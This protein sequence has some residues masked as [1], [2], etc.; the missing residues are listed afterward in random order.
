[1]NRYLPA[2]AVVLSLAFAGCGGGGSSYGGG[3]PAPG[4][5]ATLAPDANIPQ[6]AQV[7]SNTAWVTSPGQM[8]LYTFDLDTAGV[9]NCG[10]GNGCTGNWPPL[11]ASAG[12]VAQGNFSLITRTNPNGQQWAF[13]TKPIYTFTGDSAPG[14]GNGDGVNA[15]G[16]VWHIARPSAATGGGG[17]GTGCTGFYC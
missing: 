15:F 2:C 1:M 3:N 5:V 16:A 14:Q 8:T 11:M 9:S 17:G 13:E 10:S 7:K 12:A 6:Q 4:P